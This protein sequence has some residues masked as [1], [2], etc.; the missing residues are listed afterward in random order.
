VAVVYD[1]AA[2]AARLYVNGQRVATGPIT[3][4]LS[5]V[6]DLN[7]YLGRA[8][9]TDPHFAGEFDE[10]RVYRG[11]FL[12]DEVAATF[13]AGPD[14]LPTLAPALSVRTLGRQARSD[15]AGQRHWIQPRIQCHA[16]HR[17]R[18]DRPVPGAP[19]VEGDMLK[20]FVP[21]AGRKAIIG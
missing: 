5:V 4:P 16:G 6:E 8:Q 20:S 21:I 12:D 9:W 7:V 10:F 14:Q 2:G 15:L 17:D 13:A 3:H 18:L 19:T 11:T 1:T